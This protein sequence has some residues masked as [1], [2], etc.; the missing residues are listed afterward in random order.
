MTT[1]TADTDLLQFFLPNYTQVRSGDTYVEF[2]LPNGS[3]PEFS[4]ALF[5]SFTGEFTNVDGVISGTITRVYRGEYMAHGG[6]FDE[7]TLTFKEGIYIED[8]AAFQKS[9]IIG[10]QLLMAGSD[11]LHGIKKGYGGNDKIFA[12]ALGDFDG[13]TGYDTL[14]FR[15]AGAGVTLDLHIDGARLKSIEAYEGSNLA[16]IMRGDEGANVFNGSAG[17]DTLE[18][19]GGNDRLSGGNGNDVLY[20][21][22]GADVLY[23]GRGQDTFMF[24]SFLDSTK[25]AA[26]HITSFSRADDIINLKTI[27]ANSEKAGNQTFKW[28]GSDKFHGKAGELRAYKSGDKTVIAG[29]VDGDKQ[30]D[31]MIYIDKAVK[32]TSLDFIL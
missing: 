15:Q 31:L 7:G 18:G 13:G 6:N 1:I 3:D 11:E 4:D 17:N 26:D 32:L 9:G 29:D 24:K 23:G 21:G 2:R 22:E 30:T 5:V 27:D 28:I 14:I 19:R 10:V 25:S 20:G 16:D 12:Y 8:L